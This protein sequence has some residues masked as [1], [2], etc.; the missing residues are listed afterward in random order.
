MGTVRERYG[1]STGTVR[2][3][4][5]LPF[6]CWLIIF[7]SSKSLMSFMMLLTTLVVDIFKIDLAFS[8]HNCRT[9]FLRHFK[10]KVFDL[11][12]AV[13]KSSDFFPRTL[14]ASFAR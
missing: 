8:D 4:S 12:T 6:S 10:Q 7:E 3:K 2:E 5:L 9:F 13:F 11:D 1:S 14:K